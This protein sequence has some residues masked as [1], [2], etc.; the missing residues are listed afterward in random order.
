[1][2]KATRSGAAESGVVS[3]T[4]TLAVSARDFLGSSSH[5]PRAASHLGGMLSDNEGRAHGPAQVLLREMAGVPLLTRVEE[6]RQWPRR[7]LLQ[8]LVEMP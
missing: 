1:M 6:V 8:D 4:P 2:C 5:L 3:A 7:G